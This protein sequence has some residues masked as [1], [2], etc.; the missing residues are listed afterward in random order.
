MSVEKRFLHEFQSLPKDKQQEVIDFIEFL[1]HK[2]KKE[3]EKLS[4]LM[5]DVMKDNK[6]A[7]KELSK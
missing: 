4:S 2:E 1:H 5:D 6:E 7:L 3:E